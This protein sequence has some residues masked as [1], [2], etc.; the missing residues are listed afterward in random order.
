MSVSSVTDPFGPLGVVADCGLYVAREWK[1]WSMRTS[2]LTSMQPLEL[3]SG[4][5]ATRAFVPT[6][7]H[8][9][10]L[11]LAVL[12]SELVTVLASIR[13]SMRGGHSLRYHGGRRGCRRSL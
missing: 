10:V 1:L 5:P 12:T 6:K 13:P 8:V 11:L 9:C 7:A 4:Q 2:V 3:V